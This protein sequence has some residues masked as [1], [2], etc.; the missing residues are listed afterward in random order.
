MSAKFAMTLLEG[1]D[2]KRHY[3]ACV[4]KKKQ[5]ILVVWKGEELYNISKIIRLFQ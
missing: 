3:L 2:K 4:W 5:I 1:K